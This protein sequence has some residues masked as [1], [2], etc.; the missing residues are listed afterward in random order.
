MKGKKF[1]TEVSRLAA[2]RGATPVQVEQVLVWGSHF[3]SERSRRTTLDRLAVMMVR[4]FIVRRALKKWLWS[5]DKGIEADAAWE[6]LVVNANNLLKMA[7][8]TM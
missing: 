5:L 1:F 7:A 3:A 8:H 2:Q 6:Q 4:E